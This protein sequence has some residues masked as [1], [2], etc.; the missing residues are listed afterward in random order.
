MAIDLAKKFNITKISDLFIKYTS[1][2]EDQGSLCAA[3]DVNIQAKF[4]LHAAEHVYKVFII[5]V[6]DSNK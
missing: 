6:D 3:I 1:H 4:Y 2:L 5:L